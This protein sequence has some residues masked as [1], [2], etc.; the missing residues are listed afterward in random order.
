MERRFKAVE[1]E[2]GAPSRARNGEC[3]ADVRGRGQ[4]VNAAFAG[5]RL[6]AILYVFRLCRLQVPAE[7]FR[8]VWMR[9]DTF[10]LPAQA[11]ERP[12]FVRNFLGF[13]VGLT[14]AC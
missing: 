14:R 12:F 2:E 13:R 4:S 3:G 8:L 10:R 9:R 11:S 6:L 1:A 7:T 5:L